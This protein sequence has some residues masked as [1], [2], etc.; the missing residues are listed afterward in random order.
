M[1]DGTESPN[2]S[3]VLSLPITFKNGIVNVLFGVF[4][5]SLAKDD[6]SPLTF[7]VQTFFDRKLQ[8]NVAN[9]LMSSKQN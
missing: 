5:R 1:H 2:H 9:E 4:S 7:D 8:I 3:K 6:S